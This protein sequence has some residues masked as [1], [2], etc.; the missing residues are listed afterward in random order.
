MTEKTVENTFAPNCTNKK[1]TAAQ[2]V[3][4]LKYG[5]FKWDDLP[6]PA[7]ALAETKMPPPPES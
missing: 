5:A 3:C 1:F 6:E 4:G 7:K 2:L